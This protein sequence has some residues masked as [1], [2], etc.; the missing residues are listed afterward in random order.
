MF[1]T[2][3]AVARALE[4]A[5]QWAGREQSPEIQPG[6]LLQGLLL[7]EEGRPWL[8]LTE[9]GLDPQ[10]L[11]RD[12]PAGDDPILDPTPGEAARQVLTR[13]RELAR[14]LAEE[15]TVASE[16]L[17]L[18]LLDTDVALRQSLEQQGLRFAALEEAICGAKGPPIPLDEP[19]HLG[20]TPDLLTTARILDA[21][22]NR[23]REA[24]RVLEDYTRFV[25][26][27]AILSGELKQLRHGLADALAA[28]PPHWLLIARDTQ[29]DVGTAI[30]TPQ[31]MDRAAALDVVQ[32]A[33]KRLQEALRSLEEF[34]KL[35]SADMAGTIEALRYRA[36]T[37]ERALVLVAGAR[38]RLEDARLYVLVSSAQCRGSLAGTVREAAEGGAQVI[39]LREKN[40]GDRALLAL[41]RD[42]CRVARKA[43]ALFILNDRPDLA[44]LCDA[45]GVHL[46]Q[47]D[48]PVSAAR[49]ILGPDALIGVS[50]HNLDQLRQA[51]LDGA[52][53]VGVG[54]TF[55]SVTKEFPELA[56]LE[57]VRQAVAAT[58]LPAFAIG[59]ITTDN[60]AEL[61]SAGARRVAVSA[62]VC[63][64]EDP[65]A[66]VATF[67]QRLSS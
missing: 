30:S 4:F 29:G 50:T 55:P 45:D 18:A 23:A 15:R 1:D 52:S 41:A 26:D 33:C 43:G 20:E 56:G 3:P 6:H 28:V 63:A 42:V 32:A 51:V 25:L 11:R 24:L 2:T 16:H 59:G 61:R 10:A 27:D 5:R 12:L 21:A 66:A 40:L 14:G 19:L 37:L 58:A 38:S 54:P 8:L 53:Y 34:G 65:R 9:A 44:R 64:A 35:A 57:Y 46:G 49:R 31:E 13:A 7:E 62:A 39:Q 22:A 17:L 67:R 47:D 36:Y 48:L 60:L